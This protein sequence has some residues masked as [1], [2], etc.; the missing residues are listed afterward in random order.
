MAVQAQPASDSLAEGVESESSATL[1]EITV[2]ARKREENLQ[3]TPI[4]VSVLTASDL[5][6]RSVSQLPDIVTFAPNLRS[7]GG[8]QGGSSGHYYIRGIGQLDFIASTDPGVGTYL[9][10]VYFGRT[11]GAAFDLLDVDRIEVLRGPQ[12]TLFG[13]NTMGGAISVVSAQPSADTHASVT[14]DGGSRNLYE[15]RVSAGGALI[16]D[17]LLADV[18]VLGKSQ[19]GWQRRL[20]DGGTFG[21]E[22]TYA[23]RAALKWNVSEQLKVLVSLDATRGRGTGDPHYLAF[24]DAARGGHPEYVVTDPRATWSG[25]FAP[26]DLDVRGSS[27]TATYSRGSLTLKSITAW[28]TLDA[29]AGVDFDGSPFADLDQIVLTRQ[30]QRSQELQL[31]G[32][33]LG[34]R[35]SWLTGLYYFG[36]R[37]SQDIPLTFYGSRIAQNNDLSNNSYAAF[38]HLTYTLTERLSVSGGARFTYETKQH[39]FENYVDLGTSHDPLFAPTTLRNHWHSFT[40]KLGVEF[41]AT[42]AVLLYSSV[43]QGFRSGGFNGRPLGSAEFLSYEPETVTSYEVGMKSESSSRRWRFNTAAFYSRYKD[44]QLTMSES[45]PIGV[46]VVTGNAAGAELAGLETELSV[47]LS[48]RATLSTSA[49][50]LTNEYTQLA[51]GAAVSPDA[52]LPVAPRWTFNSSIDY[53]LPLARRGQLRGHLDYCYTSRYNF[54]FDNPPQSWQEAYGLV[55]ARLA[56]VPPS[57]SWQVAAYVLNATDRR[58]SA[59]REDILTSA[60]V[61][62]VWP[63]RPR[64]WG[65]EIEFQF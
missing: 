38:S 48:E 22:R 30:S 4:S 62:I 18:A 43:S 29:D 11:T 35:L 36:E 21:D 19:E 60:G 56:F 3:N 51:P 40:P 13:R 65:A 42:P 23:A 53:A 25:Q 34:D 17:R 59:F 10:G 58:H 6:Q 8:P 54:L 1:Q 32:R 46:I 61:A 52:K 15:A 44:I 28:R 37:V 45:S 49:G 14:L 47:A 2:T 57:A 20:I 27:I 41:Q 12:G 39:A 26:D 9:D 16:E 50:Y 5:T 31:S 64:E 7:S 63:A 33:A 55:N 24:A